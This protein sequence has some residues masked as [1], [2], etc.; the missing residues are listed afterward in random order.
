MVILCWREF[1]TRAFIISYV[2]H[3]FLPLAPSK[4]G[5]LIL[6]PAGGGLRGWKGER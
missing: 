4:G 2:C 5:E 3:F 6:S 1:A